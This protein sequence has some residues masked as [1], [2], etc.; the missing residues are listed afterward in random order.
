MVEEEEETATHAASAD[1]EITLGMRTLLGV[2]FGAVLVCA[3]FFGFG[4]SLGRTGSHAAPA[5]V[6]PANAAS[7]A[8]SDDS[9]SSTNPASTASPVVKTVVS[10]DQ[11]A[12][13]ANTSQPAPAENGTQYE[14]VAT[15]DGPARR[16]AGAPLKASAKPSPELVAQS[17]APPVVPAAKPPAA[18]SRPTVETPGMTANPAA[19]PAALTTSRPAA[20]QPPAT[21]ATPTMVQIAAVSHQEDANILVS[22][23]KRHGYTVIVRNDPKDSLLH[24]QIG[25]FAN[26]DEAKAMRTR[27]LADGYNAILK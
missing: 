26:R 1:T 8:T 19:Q 22:A 15:P 20:E 7:R 3:I 24:V 10:D 13:S 9:A 14:Y 11:S 18:I 23:L 27:L 25:P 6:N 17:V 12:S 2:F 16:P 4:Y 21:G 5:P